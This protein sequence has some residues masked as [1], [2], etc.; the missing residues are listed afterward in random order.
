VT[1]ILAENAFEALTG[2]ETAHEM[3]LLRRGSGFT[4]EQVGVPVLLWH[5]E[6]DRN[7]PLAHGRRV[8]NALP[9]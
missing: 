7:V 4:L 1:G 3:V 6:V 9:D 2:D 5:G 8:A